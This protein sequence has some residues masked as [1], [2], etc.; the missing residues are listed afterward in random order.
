MTG[1]APSSLTMWTCEVEKRAASSSADTF[2]L[3]QLFGDKSVA[4]T[5]EPWRLLMVDNGHPN[6]FGHRV[7]AEEL[8][9]EL[10]KVD[11]FSP[12]CGGRN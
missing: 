9:S 6:R 7:I 1:A 3:R 8:F 2:V 12:A 5:S 11:G 10:P 4:A